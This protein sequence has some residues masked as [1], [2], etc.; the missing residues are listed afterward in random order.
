MYN[1]RIYKEYLNKDKI[2]VNGT[3]VEKFT[4]I[5]IQNALSITDLEKRIIVKFLYLYFICGVVLVIISLFAY[6]IRQKTG[7]WLLD[8]NNYSI[9]RLIFNLVV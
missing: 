6:S 1:P 3:Y 7:N 4:Q 2:Y 8:L 9:V 5:E